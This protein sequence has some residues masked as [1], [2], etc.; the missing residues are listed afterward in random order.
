ARF[1]DRG[2]GFVDLVERPG[3]FPCL[4][5]PEGFASQLV[6]DSNDLLMEV[7]RYAKGPPVDL[8]TRVLAAMSAATCTLCAVHWPVILMVEI[9]PGPCRASRRNARA[10]IKSIETITFPY[11]KYAKVM[12]LP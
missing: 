5:E 8:R 7:D 4:N 3:A 11:L 12:F 9:A 2:T 6:S 10:R 1:V